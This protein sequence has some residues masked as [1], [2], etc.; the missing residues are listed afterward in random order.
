MDGGSVECDALVEVAD[1]LRWSVPELTVQFAMRALKADADQAVRT[2]AHS[3]LA[4]SLVT[5]GRHAEAVEPALAALRAA[6]AGGQIERSARLRVAI[7]ACARALGEPLTGCEVLRPVLQ[8]KSAKPATRAVALGQFVTC[9]AHVGG[10]DD[11]E[12]ALAEAERLLASDDGLSQDARRVEGALL[13]VRSASYHRRH[14]DTEAAADTARAGLA[15]LAKLHDPTAEGGRVRARLTL[16]LVCALLDEGHLDEAVQAAEPVLSE[17][18]RAAAAPAIGRLRLALATRVHIPAGRTDVGRTLLCDVVYTA[19]RHGL[20]SLLADAWTFL[21]HADEQADHPTEALHALRSAR[22]A[23]YRHMRAVDLARHRLSTEFGLEQRPE[24]VVSQLRTIVRSGA[25]TRPQPVNLPEQAARR[26]P[27]EDKP[28]RTTRGG[29]FALTLVSVAPVGTAPA[30]EPAEPPV[31]VGGD[32]ALNALASHVRDLAPD[33]AELLR[34]DLG[35]F[36]VLL[37][38]TTHAEAEHLAA[39]IRDRAIESAWLV[40]DQGRD[41]AIRTGVATQPAAGDSPRDGVDALLDAARDALSRPFAP[42]TEPSNPDVAETSHPISSGADS[43]HPDFERPG[44]PRLASARADLDHPDPPP[45]KPETEFPD[46]GLPDLGFPDFALVDFAFGEFGGR[47]FADTPAAGPDPAPDQA[48]PTATPSAAE[49]PAAE[50]KAPPVS[51]PAATPVPEVADEPQGVSALLEAARSGMREQLSEPTAADAPLPRRRRRAADPEDTAAATDQSRVEE[52][53]AG[54]SA[55]SAS[56][57]LV[58]DAEAKPAATDSPSRRDRGVVEAE[59]VATAPVSDAQ[60]LLSRFG[61]EPRGGGGRRR[62][63]DEDPYASMSYDDSATTPPVPEPDNVPEPPEGPNI[64]TPPER[65]PLPVE[66]TPAPSPTPDEVPAPE[67]APDVEPPPSTADMLARLSALAAPAVDAEAAQSGALPHRRAAPA[68]PTSTDSSVVEDRPGRRSRERVADPTSHDGS[69]TQGTPGG[70]RRSRQQA[71]ETEQSAA[72]VVPG[73]D[74]AGET[75]RA[76]PPR[77][78]EADTGLADV[79]SDEERA[80]AVSSEWLG[81]SALRGVGLAGGTPLTQPE[82]VVAPFPPADATASVIET[83]GGDR[84]ADAD[85]HGSATG[86]RTAPQTQ[87]AAADH[88]TGPAVADA[89]QTAPVTRDPVTSPAALPDTAPPAAAPPAPAGVA[90]PA[91]APVTP[92]GSPGR[93]GSTVDGGSEDA[94]RYTEASRSSGVFDVPDSG[95]AQSTAPPG[96]SESAASAVVASSRAARRAAADSTPA[97][98]AYSAIARAAAAPGD[99][100]KPSRA[101]RRASAESDSHSSA[102]HEDSAAPTGRR[103]E[104]SVRLTRRASA[105]PLDATSDVSSRQ[106]SRGSTEATEPPTHAGSPEPAGRR[107]REEPLGGS[108]RQASSDT[109]GTPAEPAR[110]TAAAAGQLQSRASR[111]AAEQADASSVSATELP[112]ET[113]AAKASTVAAQPSD[114]A[115]GS[116]P[117]VVREPAAKA[118]PPATATEER[119]REHHT[120]GQEPAAVARE[121]DSGERAA[122]V[123]ERATF[124]EESAVARDRDS[125]AREAAA[126]ARE[127]ETF[128]QESV[129]RGHDS[130][131]GERAAV[132]RERATF[133]EESAVARDHGSA[134]REAAAGARERETFGQESVARGHDSATGERPA[135]VRERATFGEESAVARDHDSAARKPAAVAH[136]G[137]TSARE[138][139]AQE[140]DSTTREP[141]AV[142]QERDGAVRERDTATREP[143][144]VA[145]E[146][147]VAREPAPPVDVI[148]GA[149]RSAAAAAWARRTAGK[150]DEERA[151]R[152][153]AIDGGSQAAAVRRT[154]RRER[155]SSGLAELLAEAMVAYQETTQPPPTPSGTW[156]ADARAVDDIPAPPEEQPSGGRRRAPEDAAPPATGNTRSNFRGRH[157]SSEWAPADID[158]G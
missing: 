121:R 80:T 50:P 29:T 5:L 97:G 45:S 60:A 89:P 6:T 138:R 113:L 152:L 99:P 68:E 141:A 30:I 109:T 57:D 110:T 94:A 41:L 8:T 90:T 135:V 96:R 76:E 106:E 130:A 95:A 104:P 1:R 85:P 26:Q 12:D 114:A 42:R 28:S 137:A 147:A 56:A 16:E 117:V 122:V 44:S 101:S 74:R 102:A 126:V 78:P 39:T 21:A 38:Q 65:P 128:G 52:A 92:T 127:R 157:R 107:S 112:A 11:L 20:D 151:R 67:P 154:A 132:V 34:T 43:E 146:P 93:P 15:M 120:F 64:P 7:A 108:A 19:D 18:V 23:E 144:A 3:L 63:P 100:L 118:E 142:D 124:G 40:D 46:F 54:P 55:G 115:Q 69:A 24:R 49:S 133:G 116:G 17:P 129:A 134:A 14:G 125:A 51:E 79:E 153:S 71:P 88:P 145:Q 58:A 37:P 139:A 81:F 48:T 4:P 62:A 53:T 25:P 148:P 143:A 36:A 140:R 91:A 33:K 149:A 70:S 87:R 136:E 103:V 82:S 73:L 2:R 150:P 119:A 105:E 13:G 35:E 31:P 156:A 158:S 123:R 77:F 32:V 131:T 83:R 75:T 9:A 59:E 61:I 98:D 84:G 10:R 72:A 86:P 155:S 111:R 66:P 22:A 27:A 47:S